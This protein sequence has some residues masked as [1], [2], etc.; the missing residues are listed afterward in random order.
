VKFKETDQLIICWRIS[1]A[2]SVHPLAMRQHCEPCGQEIWAAPTSVE[3]VSS[4]GFHLICRECAQV[5]A[6][7]G[8]ELL[9]LGRVTPETPRPWDTKKN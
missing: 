3:R 2:N 4:G 5:L 1:Q 8:H 7:A 6:E 9:L